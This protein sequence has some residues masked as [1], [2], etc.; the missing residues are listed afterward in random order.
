S[1]VEIPAAIA[2]ALERTWLTA[3][4]RNLP[5]DCDEVVGR[6]SYPE[7]AVF[8]VVVN[9][10]ERDPRARAACI[11]YHGSECCTCGFSFERVYGPEMAGRIQV[12]HLKE[13]SRVGRGYRVNPVR[14]LRPLCPN[15]HVVAH[16]RRPAVRLD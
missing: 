14:D 4:G 15:C 2:G 16:S 10:Y 3:G 6:R 1:G 11:R 8:R 9:A 12:H 5:P 13:L 7:G